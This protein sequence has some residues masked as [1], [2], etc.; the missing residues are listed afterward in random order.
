MFRQTFLF[1]FPQYISSPIA[2]DERQQQ[3][4]LAWIGESHYQ[5]IVGGL[6]DDDDNEECF[7][8]VSDHNTDSEQECKDNNHLSE[9]EQVPGVYDE[10]SS[11]S[12]EEEHSS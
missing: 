10:Q 1:L 5:E 2:M 11:S 9:Q 12:D 7:Y 8:K 3:R 6:E 4:I